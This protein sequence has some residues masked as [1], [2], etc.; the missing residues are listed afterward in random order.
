MHLAGNILITG[1]PV[2]FYFWLPMWHIHFLGV[3]KFLELVANFIQVQY[4]IGTKATIKEN[5]FHQ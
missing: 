5:L 3:A 1:S 4:F 2:T